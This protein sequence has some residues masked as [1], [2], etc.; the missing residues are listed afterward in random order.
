MAIDLPFIWAAI[1]AFAVLAYVILDGFDLGVGILFPFF[2]EKHDRDV[3]M[4]SVAPVW[5]GN[6]T[7]LVLGGG[8]LMAVFPLAYATILPAL[9]V[10]LLLMVLGLIFRGVAFEY[11]W[12]TRRGEFLWDIAFSGGSMVAAFTQGVA[13]GALVQGI[14]VENRAYVGGWWDWLTP[15]S[16]ATGFALLVGY[17]LLGATWLVMKTR[18]PLA[19]RARGYAL[20]A[21]IGTLLAMGVFSLWTPFL[22]PLYFDRWFHWPTLLFSLLVPLLVL[23]CFAL[24]VQGLRTGHDS[25]PFIAALGL[26]VL[27]FAGIGISFYPYIVPTALTIW[28]AA[29]PEES[30]A[31]LLVGA[32]VLIPMILGYTA[33]AYWVFRGKVDPEEGYH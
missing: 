11:R 19:E 18:G 17:A 10:P 1:I 16:V 6:E 3:M 29:A 23:G 32:L 15:F 30:L 24:L 25:R 4:N 20:K 2:K 12:R 9:Y 26:F 7:W 13:L 22:E 31:F 21:G 5:D 27:G 33:Y 14:P 28:Q 8:G